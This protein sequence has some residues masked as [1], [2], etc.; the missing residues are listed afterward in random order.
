MDLYVFMHFL[1]GM[2]WLIFKNKR[3]YISCAVRTEPTNT[4]QVNLK[5]Y[6]LKNVTVKN[7]LHLQFKCTWKAITSYK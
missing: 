7:C 1:H 6:K 3:W 2:S 4:L 5:I